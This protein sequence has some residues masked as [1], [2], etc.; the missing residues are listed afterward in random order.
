MR[1]TCL[2]VLSHLILNDMMKVKGHI[3]RLAL[4]LQDDDQRISGLAHVF[5]HELSRKAFKVRA[6]IVHAYICGFGFSVALQSRLGV[7]MKLSQLYASHGHAFCISSRARP[8]KVQAR[9]LDPG[10]ISGLTAELSAPTIQFCFSICVNFT[11]WPDVSHM[12]EVMQSVD[13]D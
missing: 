8:F 3:A 13:I 7:H 9:Y 2:M 5:F 1:K 10:Q 6:C 4:C 12:S 11:I